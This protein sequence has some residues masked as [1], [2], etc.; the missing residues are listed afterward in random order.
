MVFKAVKA[1]KE[2]QERSGEWK[3][4][5]IRGFYLVIFSNW[6]SLVFRYFKLS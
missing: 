6:E 4:G 3:R 5:F 1:K 2:R